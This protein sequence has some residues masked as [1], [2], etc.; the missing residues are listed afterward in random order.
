MSNK[1]KQSSLTAY[2]QNIWTGIFSVFQG[3]RLTIT[4]FFKPKV[5]LLYPEEKPVIPEGATFAMI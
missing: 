1:K 2:F 3:L 5:T 4:Y